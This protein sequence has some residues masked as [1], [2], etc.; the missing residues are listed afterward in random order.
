M[1]NATTTALR[2]GTATAPSP[3]HR[4]AAEPQQFDWPLAY[5]AEKLLR[6]RI[7]VFL[8]RNTFA[9][10][11]AERMRDEAGTDFFEWTDHLVLSSNE[12]KSTSGPK[13]LMA[14]PSMNIRRPRCR[15]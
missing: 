7:G 10:K 4:A 13:H 1:S 6:Q 12:E 5:G 8:E 2:K 11:L 3:R 15:A 9:R 14:R